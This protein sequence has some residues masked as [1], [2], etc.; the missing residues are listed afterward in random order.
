MKID[1]KSKQV[2]T[3]GEIMSETYKKTIHDKCPTCSQRWTREI[4]VPVPETGIEFIAVQDKNNKKVELTITMT[5]VITKS[6]NGRT[7]SLTDLSMNDCFASIAILANKELKDGYLM[8]VDSNFMDTY[9]ISDRRIVLDTTN[10]VEAL[11]TLK[12]SMKQTRRNRQ[13]DG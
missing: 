3:K 1:K 9:M 11:K 13:I 2:L 5:N 4:D 8:R 6:M 12:K 7:V 10:V